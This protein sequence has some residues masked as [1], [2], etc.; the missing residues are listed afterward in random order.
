[1]SQETYTSTLKLTSVGWSNIPFTVYT[2]VTTGLSVSHDIKNP[3][4]HIKTT[5]HSKDYCLKVKTTT[6]SSNRKEV[7][8]VNAGSRST[9][10]KEL[11]S[12][13][14]LFQAMRP[15]HDPVLFYRTTN[16]N[17]DSPTPGRLHWKLD[18]KKCIYLATGSHGSDTYVR[19]INE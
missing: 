10:I 6:N 4:R 16:A 9:P 14:H 13:E 5:K 17:S 8:T 11:T 18:E 15:H 3:Q 7:N 1:M 19:R 2:L 12:Q